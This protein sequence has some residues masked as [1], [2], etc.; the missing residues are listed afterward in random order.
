MY[1]FNVRVY[2]I[3][4]NENN[5]VLISDEKTQN[6][7]F[8]K[9]PGGGLEYGEGLI[10]ALKREFMEECALDI[11]IVKHIY[12]TDFYEKSSFNES[13]ILSVY[14]QVRPLSDIKFD[15]KVNPFDFS[16]EKQ[17]DKVEV[18][19]FVAFDKLRVEELT[20]KTDKTAWNVFK[21]ITER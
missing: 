12:T 8:T 14:Y 13:Q 3:L 20:F 5:E 6:V 19:R 2:G 16:K 21:E 11:E 17:L 4:V 1:L 9:F 15:I 7:S 18:F 10:D